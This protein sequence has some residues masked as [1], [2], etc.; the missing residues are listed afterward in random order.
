MD[1]EVTRKL[2]KVSLEEMAKD[3]GLNKS[4]LS[5][6]P[7][8][9]RSGFQSGIRHH[10]PLARAVWSARPGHCREE[11]QV[12]SVEGVPGRYK[13]WEG[14]WGGGGGGG[15]TCLAVLLFLE[16]KDLW[17]WEEHE[18]GGTIVEVWTQE[19]RVLCLGGGAV[20]RDDGENDAGREGWR[21]GE[22]H[23]GKEGEMKRGAGVWRDRE[24]QGGGVDGETERW[25]WIKR[26]R[27][28]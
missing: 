24:M 1:V 2:I 12:W 23:R 8:R 15:C 11:G 13:V 10:C 20:S 18:K 21:D 22:M 4:D 26:L 25:G 17:K 9:R 19:R 27:D 6:Q 3:C 14:V 28:A 5:S 16:E 7:R